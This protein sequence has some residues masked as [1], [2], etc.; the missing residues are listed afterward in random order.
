MRFLLVIFILV[1]G[2]FNSASANVCIAGS[3]T[4][5]EVAG[6]A[7]YGA[8]IEN[9]AW[10]MD[11]GMVHKASLTCQDLDVISNGLNVT[12]IAL[13]GSCPVR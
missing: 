6:Y 13:Q 11:G 2:A 3:T 4:A 12:S 5:D 7:V 1:G 8:Y 10:L 9:D